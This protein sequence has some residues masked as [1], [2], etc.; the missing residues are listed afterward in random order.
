MQPQSQ[1]LLWVPRPTA[2]RQVAAFTP[3]GVMVINLNSTN[4]FAL[5]GD[6]INEGAK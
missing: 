1:P 3:N 6:V 2:A 4:Q 5:A